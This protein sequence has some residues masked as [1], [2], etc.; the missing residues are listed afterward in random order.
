MQSRPDIIQTIIY[1]TQF[2]IKPDKIYWEI[3]KYL[4][5]YLNGTR[6]K[7]IIFKLRS[8]PTTTSEKNS[9][10]QEYSD[11]NW[12]SDIYTGKSTTGYLFICAG[13][14]IIWESIKQSVVALSTC[15]AE[16][17]AAAYAAQQAN[18]LREILEKIEPSDITKPPPISIAIDNQGAI[19]LAKLEDPNRRT[20]HINIRYYYIRD[21][22][23]NEII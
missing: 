17:I 21:Y 15:E 19:A 3:L 1:L 11:S 13:N 18:W 23:K 12:A 5:R 14:S 16:Y 20:K 2:N 22:I 8:N 7:N 6:T 10:I 4:L 9:H